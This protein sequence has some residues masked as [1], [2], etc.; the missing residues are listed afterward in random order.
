MTDKQNRLSE[1]EIERANQINL[2]TYA[3]NL[4]L[5][6]KKVGNTYKVKEHGGLFIDA[7]GSRWNWF[8]QNKGGG[9]IQFVMELEGKNWRDA[10]CTLLN[11]EQSDWRE[12]PKVVQLTSRGEFILPERNKAIKHVVDYLVQ[13]R[14]IDREIVY[15]FINAGKIYEN[16][17]R[18]CVFVGYDDDFHPKYASVR[19]TNTLGESYRGDVKN[20][21]KSYPFCRVGSSKTVCVFEAPIDLLSYLTLLEH[22][23]VPEKH[24]HMISLGGVSSKALEYYLKLNPEIE[25]I[26]LCLDN[27]DAGHFA[28]RQLFEKYQSQYKILR[29]CPKGKDFNEDLIEAKCAVQ[30]S[31]V[32]EALADYFLRQSEEVVFG[33]MIEVTF[34]LLEQEEI[35]E[36]G[37]EHGENEM[38]E[39]ELDELET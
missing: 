34:E 5:E 6:L 26:M 22:Y 3:Q 21:D 27:D 28:C 11:I 31:A 18:S 12:I 35:I 19:S 20:S 30:L 13:S 36:G 16:D 37:K 8:S 33:E 39:Q 4:G 15:E 17:H 25:K 7:N 32:Q 23:E 2:V 14:A 38:D 9:P 29:H 10:V 24:H 1:V